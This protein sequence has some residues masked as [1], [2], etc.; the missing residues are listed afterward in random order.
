LPFPDIDK[1]IQ[2]E[3]VNKFIANIVKAKY[4]KKEAIETLE[5]AKE[6]IEKILFE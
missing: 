4:L 5:K 3:I 6:E 2:D 1:T